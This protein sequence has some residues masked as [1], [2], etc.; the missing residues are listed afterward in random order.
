MKLDLVKDERGD[1]PQRVESLHS[2]IAEKESILSEQSEKIKNLTIEN[3]NYE[4]ELETLK[5][6]L[7]KYQ[8]Q[9]YQVKTNK[10]YDAI[11]HETE[12]V[13]TKIDDLE[14]KI[15]EVEE[16]IENLTSSNDTIEKELSEMREDFQESDSELKAKISASSE[17][18]NILQQERQ[19]VETKLTPQQLSAYE[20]IRSAKNGVAVAYCNGGVCSGCYSFIPPQKVV[21]I[22]NMKRLYYC[23]SCGRIL[24]WDNNAE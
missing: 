3:K 9:L 2:T 13:K 23:E 10:E 18:E 19:I 24:I 21:E 22:R 1:L 7:N 16:T 11:S 17:E 8:D 15:L 4:L 5:V 6:Q 20:R 12:T 14:R